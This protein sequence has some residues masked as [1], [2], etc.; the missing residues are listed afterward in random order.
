MER[1]VAVDRHNA[2]AAERAQWKRVCIVEGDVAVGHVV[3]GASP[4]ALAEHPA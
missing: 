3:E 2:G 1:D 4:A